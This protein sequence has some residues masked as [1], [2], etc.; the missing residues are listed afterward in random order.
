[1]AERVHAAVDALTGVT[2]AEPAASALLGPTPPEEQRRPEP[3]A[4]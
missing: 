2:Y 4:T 1:M 3:E